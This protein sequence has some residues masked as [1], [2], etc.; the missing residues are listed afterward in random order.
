MTD[1]TQHI[2]APP[3]VVQVHQ[4]HANVHAYVPAIMYHASIFEHGGLLHVR[5]RGFL[6]PPT[7]WGAVKVRCWWM[8]ND[9][10]GIW[11]PVSNAMTTPTWVKDLASEYILAKG[12]GREWRM[13]GRLSL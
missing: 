9:K 4:S 7:Y 11:H 6:V 5:A 1:E 3:K 10:S 13:P 12:S 8:Y 2:L